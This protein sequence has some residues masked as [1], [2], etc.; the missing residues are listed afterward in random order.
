MKK[1]SIFLFIASLIFSACTTRS[2]NTEVASEPSLTYSSNSNMMMSS[3]SSMTS[4][5]LK[6][7]DDFDQTSGERY[8][9]I[10]ENP[11]LETSR[12]PLSTF[13]VD[14]DTASYS[15][16]RR[17]LNHG[18]MPPKNAVRI[19]ELINYFE[20]DYPQPIGDLPFS[21]NTEVAACAWN[22]K[23]KIVSIGLQGRKVS[24]EDARHPI[25]YFWLMFPVQ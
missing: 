13:S 20:Y 6:K 15:N 8:A 21:V 22:S 18:Q 2:T 10:D 25:W 17:Y 11:F 16:V 7:V 23:N 12:A 14:V 9:E 5:E 4:T 3:N 1:Y 24:L 19:E